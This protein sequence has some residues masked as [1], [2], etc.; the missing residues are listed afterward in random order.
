MW[1]LAAPAL[2]PLI[3]TCGQFHKTF[4]AKFTLLSAY[5]LS[6]DSSYAT[7]GFNHAQKS[8][9]K[10]SPWGLYHKTYYGRNLRFL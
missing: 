1:A 2:W 3:V 5:C 8:F 7:G 9:M 4:L 6:F 10:L